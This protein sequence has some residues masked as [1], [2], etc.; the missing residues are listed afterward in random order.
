MDTGLYQKVGRGG[1]GNHLSEGD[2]EAQKQSALKDLEAQASSEPITARSVNRSP[3][4]Y[5]I[6]GRGG[7]GN[8][9]SPQELPQID[10]VTSGS[11]TL[12]LVSTTARPSYSGRGGVG[13]YENNSRMNEADGTAKKEA[14]A[15]EM[16]KREQDVTKEVEMELKAPERA[17][18]VPE[19]SSDGD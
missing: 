13:N 7:F 3:P 12:T 19:R 11:D 10:S 17:H 6:S 14:S 4:K 18:L 1:I 8:L 5:A 16:R 9:Y 2:I 15:E